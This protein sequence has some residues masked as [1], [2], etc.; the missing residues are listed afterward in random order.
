[1][2]AAKPNMENIKPINKNWALITDK[3]ANEPK[4]NDK[5]EVILYMPQRYFFYQCKNKEFVK[6]NILYN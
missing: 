4:I 1:M 5:Y 6:L 3:A 2:E